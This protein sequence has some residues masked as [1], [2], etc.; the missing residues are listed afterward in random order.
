MLCILAKSFQPFSSSRR[1][2]SL[3]RERLYNFHIHQNSSSISSNEKHGY[4]SETVLV[5]SAPLPC[6]QQ[7]NYAVDMCGRERVR[8][9]PENIAASSLC[10][11]HA[12]ECGPHQLRY[13]KTMPWIDLP[14]GS[15]SLYRRPSYCESRT[16]IHHACLETDSF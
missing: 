3:Q 15:S 4:F 6:R 8:E 5:R 12:S 13:P 1:D 10:A 7:R 11:F 9:V 16:H 14:A 2:S